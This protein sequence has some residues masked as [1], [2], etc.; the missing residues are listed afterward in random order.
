MSGTHRSGVWEHFDTV[1]KPTRYPA[2]DTDGQGM[3][4]KFTPADEEDTEGHGVRFR[5][6]D[7]DDTEGNAFRGR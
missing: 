6:E 7:A 5:L 3:Q 2:E 4:F 1:Q